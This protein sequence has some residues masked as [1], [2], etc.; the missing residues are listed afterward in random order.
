[1]SLPEALAVLA[2][3]GFVLVGL[4]WL[5]DGPLSAVADW[6]LERIG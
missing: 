2:V 5:A 3:I 4:G 6:I 1:M